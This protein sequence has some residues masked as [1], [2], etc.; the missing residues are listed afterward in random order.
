L[1]KYFVDLH[2]HIGETLKKRPVKI[3]ASRKLNLLNIIDECIHRKGIDIIGIV[4]CG[5][6]GVLNDIDE[7]IKKDYIYE[8]KG[9]GL[10]YRDQLTI[11]PGAEV[12]SCESN[13]GRGHYLSFFPTV[14]QIRDYSNFLSHYIKNINLSTQQSFLPAQKLGET[15]SEIGGIF[16]PAHAFTPHK[17]L[18]GSC[19]DSLVNVFNDYASKIKV[20]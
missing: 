4:D 8:L 17:S 20:L 16:F 12:E 15:T 19:G 2:I 18:F 14:A 7:L 3:T 11:I 5:S 13:G 9:G 1:P 6:P 10:S